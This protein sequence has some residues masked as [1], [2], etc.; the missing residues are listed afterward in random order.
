MEKAFLGPRAQSGLTASGRACKLWVS[1]A[2]S[3]KWGRNSYLRRASLQREQVN[4]AK[5]RAWPLWLVGLP[6][7][8]T[9]PFIGSVSVPWPLGACFPMSTGDNPDNPTCQ[10]CAEGEP[11]TLHTQNSTDV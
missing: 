3:A 1:A 7:N 9:L 10:G 5:G 4:G 8:P 6:V 2:A 11:N